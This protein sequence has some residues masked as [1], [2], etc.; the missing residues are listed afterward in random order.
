MEIVRDIV[1]GIRKFESL[2]DK[3]LN[4]KRRMKDLESREEDVRTELL[5]YEV[6][7]SMRKRRKTVKNWLT[8]V[9]EMK[10]QVEQIEQKV[11]RRRFYNYLQLQNTV[12]KVTEEVKEL[13][14][15]GAFPEGLTVVAHGGRGLPLPLPTTDLLGQYLPFSRMRHVFCSACYNLP[16]VQCP[17][18]LQLEHLLN[19]CEALVVGKI[20]AEAVPVLLPSQSLLFSKLRYSSSSCCHNLPNYFLRRGSIQLENLSSILEVLGGRCPAEVP[21]HLTCTFN[22]LATIRIENCHKIKALMSATWLSQF[23]NLATLYVHNCKRLVEIVQA[24]DGDQDR[25]Q[26]GT[27]SIIFRTLPKLRNLHLIDLPELKSFCSGRK[28]VSDSLEEIFIDGCPQLERLPLF[29]E[30]D[31]HPPTSLRRINVDRGWWESIEFDLPNTKDILKP[32]CHFC[33]DLNE[34][35]SYSPDE[36]GTS[37][38]R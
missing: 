35:A 32:I 24:P 2:D 14:Q 15:L 16:I 29:R 25:D 8:N 33:W 18:Y 10:N 11:K 13:T 12:D 34:D 23:P 21:V 3:I 26:E 20:C 28:L 9:R 6:P 27:G 7:F 38:L 4:L 36:C 37:E 22:S 30:E 1:E 5:D 19:T 17:E 31:S